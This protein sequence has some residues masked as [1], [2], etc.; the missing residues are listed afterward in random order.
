[1]ILPSNAS[2][3]CAD[4]MRM[5]P[6]STTGRDRVL[7]MAA[8]SSRYVA[9]RALRKGKGVAATSRRRAPRVP[10]HQRDRRRP[11]RQNTRADA[12]TLLDQ[13]SMLLPRPEMRMTR[14]GGPRRRSNDHDAASSGT[15]FTNHPASC[16]FA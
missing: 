4:R 3:N 12:P 7:R 1:M 5:N 16:R 11:R 10:R 8:A 15:H 9:V 6:A 2:T 14:T 13:R